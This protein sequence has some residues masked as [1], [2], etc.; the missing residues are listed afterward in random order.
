MR[1]FVKLTVFSLSAV[2]LLS[3]A[4]CTEADFS[5]EDGPSEVPEL[6][7]VLATIDG[8]PV[9]LSDLEETAADQLAQME[10]QY[11]NQRYQLLQDAITSTVRD[12]LL[13]EEA[14]DRGMS[15]EELITTLTDGKDQVTD[16]DVA[17]F[18][19]QNQARLQ[20][21][22]IEDVAPQ[23]KNYLVRSRTE[24]AIENHVKQLVEQ[25][26]VVYLLEPDRTDFSSEDSPSDGPADAPVTVVEFSD[27]EC[28]YCRRVVETLDQVK[29]NYGDQVRIVFRQFPLASHPNAQKAAEASLCANDQDK[30][31]PMHD[32][33]FAEQSSLDVASLKKKA[34]RLGLDRGAFDDCLDS[35]RHAEK[36]RRDLEEGTSAGVNGTP[37]LFVNGVN[38]P[39]GAVPYETIAAAIDNELLRVGSR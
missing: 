11:K 37:S 9:T 12:R 10:T 35:S 25:R 21:R 29:E 20:N 8:N 16:E 31:W 2:L 1:V 30:F 28:S 4:G 3:L 22:P 14:A 32:L 23:I 26:D 34:D 17:E 39:G 27:F 15:K 19:R 6:P 38:L 7:E 5:R 13:D 24:A 33:L 36:V 18:Y